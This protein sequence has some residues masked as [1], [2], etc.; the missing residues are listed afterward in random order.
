MQI[1]LGLDE[2]HVDHAAGSLP[3]HSSGVV[4]AARW[5]LAHGDALECMRRLPAGSIDL[6]F[7]DPPYFLSNGGT[8]CS[9]GKRVEV[10]K[11]DWDE[12]RGLEF[13]HAFNV[14]WLTEAQRVLKRSGSIWVTGTHHN[15]FSVGFAMQ[16]LGFHILNTVT[17]CKPNAPPNLGCR[18][19]THST[20]LAIWAA[21]HRFDPLEHVFHY[22]VLKAENGGKQLRDYWEIPVT[23][24]SE[25]T[26]GKHPTQKPL[27]LLRRIMKACAVPGGWCLDPFLGSGPTA[28]AA[29]EAGMNV[30]GVDL[31]TNH[32]ETAQRRIAAMESR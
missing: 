26:H 6:A 16:E 13:D 5:V 3:R 18:Q 8:T 32:L 22:D 11:G 28:V 27:A 17:I 30:I 9:G 1:G 31:D 24:Q 12:S 25:K 19:L 2:V 4:G 7:S 23:P 10:E 21:P 14:A 20:E 15:I 29:L